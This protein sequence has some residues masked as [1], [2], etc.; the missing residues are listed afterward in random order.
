MQPGVASTNRKYKVSSTKLHAKLGSARCRYKVL[1]YTCQCVARCSH[2]VQVQSGSYPA[3]A[4]MR[5]LQVLR[6][7]QSKVWILGW[8]VRRQQQGGKDCTS[9]T[10]AHSTSPTANCT[11]PTAA[12]T[13]SPTGNS[14]PNCNSAV[15]TVHKCTRL[16]PQVH[17]SFCKQV[18]ELRSQVHFSLSK[19]MRHVP[20]AHSAPFSLSC[21]C[22]R[23]A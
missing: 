9:P 12:H 22:G 19:C 11:S 10:A 4:K 14:L 20:G 6:R 13:T 15:S 3:V 17:S 5:E 16:V 18:Y 21:R 7:K 23:G 1:S 2:V 8:D